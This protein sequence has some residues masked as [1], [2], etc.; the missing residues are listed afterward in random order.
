V[1]VVRDFFSYQPPYHEINECPALALDG[2]DDESPLGV[3]LWEWDTQGKL[4]D[5]RTC[6]STTALTKVTVMAEYMPPDPVWVNQ[7]HKNDQESQAHFE[8]LTN[9]PAEDLRRV[10]GEGAAEPLARQNALLILLM[11]KDTG[12]AEILPALFED[13]K[14]GE[15]AIKYCPL[16]DPKVVAR[17]HDL[18][19]H[20][21][22]RIWSAAAMALACAK[23]QPLRQLLYDWFHGDDTERR[24]VAI[25]AWIE[26]D[27]VY[28]HRLFLEDWEKGGRDEDDRLVLA[29]ALLRLGNTQ[30]VGFLEAAARRAEGSRSVFAAWS[31]AQQSTVQG[32]RLMQ[33]ILDHGDSKALGALVMQAWNLEP[34]KLPHAFTADGLNEARLWVKQELEQFEENSV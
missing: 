25:Q 34:S 9:L 8:R 16:T 26:F 24:S 13:P 27:P 10:L 6:T 1:R 2:I 28:A 32:F 20:P 21:K 4:I 14:L 22:A 12:V 11:R 29:N 15:M 23:D 3:R 30:V 18:L 17:L 5:Y 33:W 19:D 31:V 7:V